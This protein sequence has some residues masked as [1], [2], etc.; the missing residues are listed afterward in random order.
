M[1]LTGKTIGILVAAAYEDLE[2][3]V[4]Y[5]RMIEAGAGVL[6]ISTTGGEEYL[7]KSKGLTARSDLGR[8]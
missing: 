2:F 8:P 5:M 3:W 7:S 6:I 1:M 4:P